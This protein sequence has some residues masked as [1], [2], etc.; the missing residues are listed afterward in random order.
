MPG[1]DRDGAPQLNRT[2]L[3]E[4]IFVHLTALSRAT[5][6]FHIDG[7]I[8]LRSGVGLPR[9]LHPAVFLLAE[10]GPMRVQDLAIRSG[11]LHSTASRHVDHL[12]RAGLAVRS[13]HPD[14][15]RALSVA[16]TDEGRAVCAALSATWAALFDELLAD[17]PIEVV[18]QIADSM[19]T[20]ADAVARN[21][22]TG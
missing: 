3:A 18:S 13:S 8:G 1:T 6:R 5:E 19:R 20:F 17:L 15:R 7:V 14:D 9:W 11:V 21:P 4:Q 2:D 22:Q 10:G 12:V 16:L